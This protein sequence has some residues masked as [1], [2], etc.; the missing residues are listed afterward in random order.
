MSQPLPPPAL[1]TAATIAAFFEGKAPSSAV[2]TR[3]LLRAFR[4][5]LGVDEGQEAGLFAQADLFGAVR[6]Q[7]FKKST[8]AAL[9]SVLRGIVRLGQQRGDYDM[10]RHNALQRALAN[11]AMVRRSPYLTRPRRLTAPSPPKALPPAPSPVPGYTMVRV[12][13]LP[14]AA[15]ARPCAALGK[16]TAPYLGAHAVIVVT[17]TAFPGETAARVLGERDNALPE[18]PMDGV[19]LLLARGL[20]RSSLRQTG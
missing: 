19:R 11:P 20:R 7:G 17:E 13:D 15:P 10:E 2:A 14:Q 12:A 4:K 8:E 6:A 3:A 16:A 18:Q 1:P 9:F 5:R